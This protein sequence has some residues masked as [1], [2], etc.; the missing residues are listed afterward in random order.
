M[1]PLERV[2]HI[3][4]LALQCGAVLPVLFRLSEDVSPL[5]TANPLNTVANAFVL[6]GVIVLM[7]RNRSVTWRVAPALFLIFAL[8]LLA[9][10]SII[11]SDYPDI[12]VRRSGALLTTTMWAWYV[13]ARFDLR[14]NIR[15]VAQTIGLMAIASLFLGAFAPAFGQGG[16]LDPEGWRGIFS[17]KN[18]LGDMMAV[19]VSTYF[20]LMVSSS[21][22]RLFNFLA[23]LISLALCVLLLILSQSRTSWIIGMISPAII[24]VLQFTKGRAGIGV[25][26]SLIAIMVLLPAVAF[27]REEVSVIAPLL[28]RSADLT[29]RTELWATLL[30][31][32]AD[33]PLLGYGLGAFWV[34]DSRN[35]LYVWSAVHWHP[36]S[37][38]NGWL[39][40]MLELGWS[41]VALLTI[42]LCLLFVKATRAVIKNADPDAPYL[43]LML[44]VIL[45]HNLSESELLRPQSIMWILIVISA[46][47]LAKISRQPPVATLA[48]E[49][50]TLRP[51]PIAAR[52]F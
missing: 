25:A 39:D 40:L 1:K 45:L 43:L 17:T 37:A 4:A 20:Y 30:P 48:I 15:I 41:G 24:L 47:A 29:G 14:E 50:R 46:T 42:Q 13:A 7:A 12:T 38:H 52:E 44:L 10:A 9:F 36:P 28:G 51:S 3:T 16:P 26:L 34:E 22:F 11:W 27:V 32:I 23:L 21:R 6:A 18:N 33:H 35:V 19:G 2:F 5:G 31:C 8:V 49:H